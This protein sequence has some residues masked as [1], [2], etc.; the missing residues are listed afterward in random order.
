MCARRPSPARQPGSQRPA[1]TR[2]AP[3]FR[4]ASLR[5]SAEQTTLASVQA[6][7]SRPDHGQIPAATQPGEVRR[8]FAWRPPARPSN[9]RQISTGLS[10]RAP[11]S[12]VTN[13]P[14][15]YTHEL[16]RRRRAPIVDNV[17]APPKPAC[18]KIA[19]SGRPLAERAR[20]RPGEPL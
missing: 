1:R 9:A 2:Q 16:S 20:R 13:R 5:R 18:S 8:D 17:A 6:S 12:S 10:L 4:P 14:P 19:G 11:Q 3:T 7:V 15:W